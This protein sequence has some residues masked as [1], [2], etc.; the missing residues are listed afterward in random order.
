[1]LLSSRQFSVSEVA[2]T[3]STHTGMGAISYEGGT[4]FRVWAKFASA[5]YVTGSFNNWSTTANPL[6]DEGN[7]YWSVDVPAAKEGDRYRY[8]IHSPFIKSESG[9][10]R[11]DPYCKH[12]LDN[13]HL[14]K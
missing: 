4:A 6:V 2:N 14:R 5:V 8:V 10:L 7:G 3:A 11:T 12:V 1:M 9:E 13:R